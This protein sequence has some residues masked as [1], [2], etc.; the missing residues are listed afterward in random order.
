MGVVVHAVPACGMGS[1]EENLKF[2]FKVN[3]AYIETW[4]GRLGEGGESL[5]SSFPFTQE[6]KAKADCSVLGG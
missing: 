6:F 5:F 1:R 2:E 4:G 3:L